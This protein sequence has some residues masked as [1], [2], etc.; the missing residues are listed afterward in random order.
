MT[1]VMHYLSS[2][3]HNQYLP[4]SLIPSLRAT[5]LSDYLFKPTTIIARVKIIAET[6]ISEKALAI[7]F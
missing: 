2:P 3:N 6:M 4:D 1:K 5:N 7:M